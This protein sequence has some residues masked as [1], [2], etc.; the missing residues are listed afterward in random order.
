[1]AGQSSPPA[2][3]ALQETLRACAEDAN[4]AGVIP[5]GSRS[6]EGF[7][8]PDSDFDLLV[9][10]ADAEA[11]DLARGALDEYING[12]YRSLKNHRDR[13]V[14]GEAG[15]APALIRFSTSSSPGATSA[16]DGRLRDRGRPV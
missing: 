12:C 3:A 15:V 8:R 5:H 7:A 16:P 1:M 9:I 2:S 13:L 4:V 6:F 14:G 10:L 11:R